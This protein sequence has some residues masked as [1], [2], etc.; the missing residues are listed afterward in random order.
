MYLITFRS[1]MI[2]SLNKLFYDNYTLVTI[3]YMDKDTF[4]RKTYWIPPNVNLFMGKLD[5]VIL[6]KLP[7]SI[8]YKGFNI[9]CFINFPVYN[10][11]VTVDL[12]L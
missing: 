11:K 7:N 2:T 12:S 6:H 5:P 1:Q 4:S 10:I 8:F 9:L 3:L